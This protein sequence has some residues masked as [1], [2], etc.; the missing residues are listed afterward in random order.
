MA[1]RRGQVTFES[2]LQQCQ[3]R[4]RE[5]PQAALKAIGKL[6]V[7]ELRP[8]TPK[9]TGKLRKSLGY[10]HKTKEN[11]LEV[12]YKDWKS[13]PLILGTLGT[14]ANNFFIDAVMR[15]VP[16]IQELIQQALKEL[17]KED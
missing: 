13:V 10:W 8:V 7:Q 9:D 12:G 16:T 14:K 11:V 6:L 15:L 2:R 17:E 1:A 5:K 3:E 4:I